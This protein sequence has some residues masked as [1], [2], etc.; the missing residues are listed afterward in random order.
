MYPLVALLGLV[1][2]TC[3]LQ[4]F[5]TDAERVRTAP[6]IGF[7]VSYAAML[8]THNWALFFGAA[9][10]LAWL[11]LLWHARGAGRA[12]LLRTGLIAYGRG[13]PLPVGGRRSVPAARRRRVRARRPAGARRPRDRGRA[14]G[15]RGRARGE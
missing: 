5:T 8:Y 6:A 9:T 4:A 15:A 3:W 10:G 14:V 2:M 7:A 13:E 12:H 1:S 11:G